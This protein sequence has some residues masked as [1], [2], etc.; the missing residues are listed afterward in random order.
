MKMVQSQHNLCCVED[1]AFMG[2]SPPLSLVYGVLEGTTGHHLGDEDDMGGGLESVIKT[3]DIRVLSLS[4]HLL[5][6]H[7]TNNKR[8]I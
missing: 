8:E 2:E 7:K 5:F 4:Q 6:T 3:E 1:R